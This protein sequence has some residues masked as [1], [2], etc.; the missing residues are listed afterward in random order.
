M[1]NELEKYIKEL[2]DAFVGIKS[3]WLFGSRANNRQKPLSDWD[4]LVFADSNTYEAIKIDEYYHRGAVDLLVVI[5]NN[6]FIKPWG[7]EKIGSINEWA[8]NEL[9]ESEAEY[10]HIKFI[11]DKPGSDSGE[12]EKLRLKAKKLFERET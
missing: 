8:W 4:L 7:K 3:I 1:N 11:S 6:Q 5:D 9:T 10:N 2:T 12:F